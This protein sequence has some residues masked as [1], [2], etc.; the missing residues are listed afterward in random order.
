MAID[1][2]VTKQLNKDFV[3]VEAQYKNRNPRYYQVPVQTA[4]K[5]CNQFKESEKKSNFRNNLFFALSAIGGCG[6][7]NL[8]AINFKPMLRATTAIIGGILSGF[9]VN[10]IC[11]NKTQKEQKELFRQNGAI[12]ITDYLKD[13]SK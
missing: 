7:G 4:D 12:D 6:L 3:Q 8:L 2:K 10:N 13:S 1:V 9:I 5:F 11:L